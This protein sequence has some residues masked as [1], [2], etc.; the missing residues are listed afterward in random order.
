M[1]YRIAF[2]GSLV[3]NRNLSGVTTSSS[4]VKNT[5]VQHLPLDFEMNS[6]SIPASW[7]ASTISIFNSG[8]S[9]RYTSSGSR[10]AAMGGGF[11]SVG[12]AN[13]S[14]FTYFS[15]FAIGSS[16]LPLTTITVEWA[17]NITEGNMSVG[18]SRYLGSGAIG[19]APYGS[20]FLT[21]YLTGS[22][23]VNNSDGRDFMFTAVEELGTNPVFQIDYIRVI[24][25]LSSPV[26]I[27]PS[28]VT[29]GTNKI[30]GTP[31]V[32]N[33]NTLQNG[34]A[35]VASPSTNFGLAVKSGGTTV[36]EAKHLPSADASED[37]Y[38]D[39]SDEQI[40]T[41]ANTSLSVETEGTDL[42]NYV[43]SGSSV[44]VEDVTVQTENP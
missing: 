14:F 2:D 8:A 26:T 28:T 12:S 40:I 34:T 36:A 38:L 42:N 10:A 13:D 5:V 4:L 19:Y 3:D 41:A 6:A 18:I 29:N 27:T 11:L 24:T 21:G 33:T 22:L 35:N 1:S 32:I 23:T 16:L 7:S 20:A 25:G 44:I 9:T 15:Q 30:G 31:I 17:I 37:A 43:D 39:S